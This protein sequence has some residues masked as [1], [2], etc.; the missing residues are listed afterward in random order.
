MKNVMFN[1]RGRVNYLTYTAMKM[2][3]KARHGVL[4]RG[5]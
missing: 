1:G 5:L 2:L 4:L 3:Y